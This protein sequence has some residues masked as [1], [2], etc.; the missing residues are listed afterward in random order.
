[1]MLDA[2]H[3]GDTVQLSGVAS[4]DGATADDLAFSVHESAE[5]LES[6]DAGA[7]LC[8]VDAP[9][10]AG[11]TQILVENPR[12][13]FATVS[14][15]YFPGDRPDAPAGVHPSAVVHDD[16]TIGD[17][18]RIDPHVWIGANV[19]VGPNCV[20]RAG[21]TIGGAGFGFERDPSGRPQRIA[22]R[23]RVTIGPDVEIGPNCSIDRAVFDET[24]IGEGA[25]LSGQVHVG[26]Q[27][28]IGADALVTFG[29]GFG[30]GSSIGERVTLHPHVSL[31]EG[32]TVG[33]DA[34][35]GMNSAVLEDV[36][37]GAKVAGS[38]AEPIGSDA[39]AGG[40]P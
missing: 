22:H 16:A 34:E 36:P 3:R 25:K 1:M 26:H 38:P 37:A 9:P 35:I 18:T 23:G 8:P 7:V 40:E 27:V 15:R 4:L 32:V 28:S 20:I 24:T 29:V 30:G 13:A 39:T 11:L 2:D 17:G 12:L 14:T 19:T 5:P 10:V 6:T 31:A 33:D 21:T